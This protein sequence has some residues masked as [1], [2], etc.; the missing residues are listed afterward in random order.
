[1][2]AV[3]NWL[4][5]R[6]TTVEVNR[7]EYIRPGP[8]ERAQTDQI[9]FNIQDPVSGGRAKELA[10]I[11][12]AGTVRPVRPVAD[13]HPGGAAMTRDPVPVGCAPPT[14]PVRPGREIDVLAVPYD[15][16]TAVMDY[17]G[18]SYL[19]S[20]RAGGVRGVA[21][22]ARRVKV[23]RDHRP[24]RAVGKCLTIDADP[25]DGLRATL[26]IT[27]GIPSATK[28][29]R[30]PPT[31]CSMCRSG[32][33]S[34]AQTW[35]HDRSTVILHLLLAASHCHSSRCPPTRRRPCSRCGRSPNRC[36]AGPS[37]DPASGRDP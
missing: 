23:L 21:G 27:R 4:L 33:S 18:S 34:P 37:A 29:W 20:D 5:P 16:A 19:E 30:S 10:E 1:M 11:R 3:S 26:H 36:P 17:D 14:I 9:L 7:D 24:E 8:L 22:R 25:S 6:G 35:S 28:R 2:Q 12:G 15:T 31:G 32:S 13:T